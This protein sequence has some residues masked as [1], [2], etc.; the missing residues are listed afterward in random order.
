MKTGM[1]GLADEHGSWT[2]TCQGPVTADELLRAECQLAGPGSKASIFCR[3]RELA[4]D[5]LL[6]FD[7]DFPYVIALQRKRQALSWQELITSCRQKAM[8]LY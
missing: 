3:G 2:I 4:K 8:K 6:H 1:V 7:T 5:S